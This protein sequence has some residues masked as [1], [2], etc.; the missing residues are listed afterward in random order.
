MPFKRN[1]RFFAEKFL[2]KK[3]NKK[4]RLGLNSLCLFKFESF[5]LL[6]FLSLL[7]LNLENESK[8]VEGVMNRK[9]PTFDQG[10]CQKFDGYLLLSTTLIIWLDS[11]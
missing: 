7:H 3:K 4:K 9:Y 1:G 8:T 6:M 5:I 10:S 2:H 11:Q